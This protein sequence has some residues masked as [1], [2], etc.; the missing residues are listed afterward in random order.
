[1]MIITTT[2]VHAISYACV[3]KRNLDLD[4]LPVYKIYFIPKGTDLFAKNIL[5]SFSSATQ[6]FCTREFIKVTE[7]LQTKD[8]QLLY[9]S[10][11]RAY[12]RFCFTIKNHLFWNRKN[13]TLS[14]SSYYYS[15]Y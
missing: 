12:K 13:Q 5:H 1:M 6:I 7:K 15:R 10:T 2:L 9:L 11:T 4:F 8:L 3:Y 14:V